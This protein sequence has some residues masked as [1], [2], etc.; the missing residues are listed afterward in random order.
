VSDPERSAQSGPPARKPRSKRAKRARASKPAANRGD[1]DSAAT[2][3]DGDSAAALPVP[4]PAERGL[5]PAD[6][7]TLYLA[8]LRRH[9]PISREE[10][11]ALAV[12]FTEEGDRD[13]ARQLVLSNL[14]LVVKI[15]MEYRRAWANLLDLIGEGNVGLLEAVH[16]FDPY[17][18]VK[19]STYAVYWIRAYI[20]KYLLDNK[21]MVRLGTSRAQ[22]KIWYRLNREKRELERQGLAVEPKLIAERLDVSEQDVIEMQQRVE[23]GDLSL[24]APVSD[25]QG[26]A[27]YGDFVPAAGPS[28]ESAV[29]DSELS[30]VV[31]KHVHAL[32]KTLDERDQ[33]I[34]SERILAEDPRTLQ[35]LANEY[36]LTR[37]RVRQLEAAIVARLQERLQAEMVDF[38]YHAQE[39]GRGGTAEKRR[40]KRGS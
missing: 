30:E 14:R 31:K 9:A 7:L 11:H 20:L 4:I 25:E 10:E 38:E 26:A 29:G 36:G 13:A 35:E 17:R 40:P 8:E 1:S 28:A 16:R 3:A 32:A 19:L 12:R 2:G 33:R 23:R 22:R 37:E 27:R 34:L 5:G 39:R 21:S 24:D 15:A 18:G 6:A